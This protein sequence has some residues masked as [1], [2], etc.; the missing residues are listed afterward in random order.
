MNKL[1]DKLEFNSKTGRVII[2][3]NKCDGCS[4][5][6]CVKACSLY[7]RGILRIRGGRVVLVINKEEA[8]RRCIECLACEVQ[9]L[10][11]GNS[12]L[13][14]ILPIGGLEEYRRR[15]S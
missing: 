4:T 14:I 3:Y 7:G 12:A 11:H 9:C 5:F 15:W 10:L 1:G 8:G 2:N 13:K 6:A